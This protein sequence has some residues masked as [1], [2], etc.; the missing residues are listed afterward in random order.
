MSEL[1]NEYIEDAFVQI[2]AKFEKRNNEIGLEIL[3]GYE[4]QW[5][6]TGCL[7]DRQHEWLEKQLDG[8]WQ[9]KD[10]QAVKSTGKF[11]TRPEPEI[12]VVS[13][14]QSANDT[15]DFLNVMIQRK[16]KDEGKIVVDANA[17]DALINAVKN[18]RNG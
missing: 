11:S 16:L 8:S 9:S 12:F 7:S 6:A 14:E 3:D 10:K 2:R 1:S 13:N 18:L 15:D 5:G 17:I 4:E